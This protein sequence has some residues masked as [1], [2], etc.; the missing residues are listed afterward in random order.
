MR[1]HLA[2]YFTGAVSLPLL[3]SCGGQKSRPV[4]AQAPASTVAGSASLADPGPAIIRLTKDAEGVA[5]RF[6]QA[7]E[8]QQAEQA[9]ALTAPAY[10][11]IQ[12]KEAHAK[13]GSA[14]LDTVGKIRRVKLIDRAAGIDERKHTNYVKLAY[15]VAAAK[16]QG[17]VLLALVQVEGQWRVL[18]LGLHWTP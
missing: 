12:S 15:E 17:M 6:I 2:L 1:S 5:T 13:V 3:A 4:Q 10:R 8:K 16:K 14:W 18:S 7:L 9:Y 11:K